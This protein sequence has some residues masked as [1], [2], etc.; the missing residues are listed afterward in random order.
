MDTVG[1]ICG[2]DA[3]FGGRSFDDHFVVTSGIGLSTIL[4][5]GSHS[6]HAEI[7]VGAA[8]VLDQ[9]EL[10]FDPSDAVLAEGKQGLHFGP[11]LQAFILQLL[12]KQ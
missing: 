11:G 2:P 10:W 3:M 1:R 4:A 8:V 12:V 7:V 5:Y 6:A 9:A